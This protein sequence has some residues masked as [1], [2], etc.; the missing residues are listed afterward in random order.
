VLREVLQE[1]DEIIHCA[2]N[3]AFS[4]RK[5]AEVEAVN[6]DGMSHV[7]DCAR[8]SGAYFFHHVSTAF[9]AGK[10]SGTCF[11]APGTPREFCNV[12]EETKWR[13]ERMAMAACQAAGLRLTIYRPS[14]V[15]GDSRTGRSLLFNAVY[16]PVRTALFMRDLYEAD[17]RERGGK[18]AGEMG[19]RI[20]ADGAIRLPFRIEVASQGGINLIPVDYFTDAFLA[21]MEGAP[22][23]GIFH[24]VNG[25]TTRIEDIIDYSCRL[26][27]MTGIRACTPDALRQVPKNALEVLYDRY[28][29]AYSPYMRDTR[30]FDTAV[31]E[32][33]LERRGVVCPEFDYEVFARCMMFAVEVGWGLRLFTTDSM[34]RT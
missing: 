25:R 6:V 32:A 9:V 22:E 17:I 2:S 26:F 20:E 16:Y 33:L 1:T 30:V 5:K 27:R 4:A 29:E 12:Y 3:T 28:V 15:Y 10:T 7:L 14:I 13:G 24:I 21:L 23:G 18:K 34:V 31:S 19:V 8:A 11:E